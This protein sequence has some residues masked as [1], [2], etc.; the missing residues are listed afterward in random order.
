MAAQTVKVT[1]LQSALDSLTVFQKTRIPGSVAWALNSFVVQLRKEEQQR[2]TYTFNKTNAFTRNAPLFKLAT[3]ENPRALFFLRDNAPGGN[4]P[5][6]YLAPQVDGGPVYL[7]RFSRALRRSG[8]I[9]PQDYPVHWDVGAQKATPGFISAL[10]S[11]L[12]RSAGPAKSGRQ[13]ARNLK[14]QDK[15]FILDLSQAKKRSYVVPGAPRRDTGYKGAG[16]YTRKGNKLDLVYRILSKPPTV[17]AK[18]DWNFERM[19]QMAE[20]R[21]PIL[22][23][24]KLSEF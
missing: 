13:Y 5:D 7:T 3:K 22:L 20:D 11:S 1:G 9:G 4:S 14:Y 15:Y 18:Y 16:I 10:L 17:P 12:T 21:L 8:A 6:R 23:F 19:S 24:G 2:L